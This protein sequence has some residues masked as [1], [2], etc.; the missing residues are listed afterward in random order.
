MNPRG[1]S[2]INQ[3]MKQLVIFLLLFPLWS[4]AQHSLSGSV[5]ETG[6]KAV[7]FADVA[8][9][10]AQD[11]T[12]YRAV[13]ADE[14]GFFTIGSVDNGQYIL[15]ASAIGM[16]TTNRTI[17]VTGDQ[18]LQPIVLSQTA[19]MLEGVEIV[20]KRPI[21]KRLVDR[22]EFNVE[23]SSL[24]SNNAWEI[25]SKTPGVTT[26]G[27]GSISIRGSQSILVT[28][29]DKKVY[30][31]GD[32]LKQYLESTSGE[33]V[34]SV[35]VIT[36]PPAKY[37]AQGAAVVNIK[38]KKVLSQ[39]YKGSVNTAYV[40]SIYPKAVTSTGHFYK[41][42]KLSLMGRYTFGMGEYVSE[43]E[44]VTRYYDENG[45]IASEWKSFL[46]RKSKSLEQHSYRLQATYELDSLNTF[47]IG[48][49]AFQAPQQF[50]KY[51][52]PTAIY[53]GDRLLDSLYVTTNNRKNPARNAAYN[54]LYERV[55]SEKAKLAINA[56]FTNYLSKDNQ[57][58]NT[59]F[60]LPDGTPYRDTRFVNNS[61]QAIKLF[62]AQ[63]DYSNERNGTFESGLKYSNVSADSNLD[64]RDDIGGVLV[65]NL[66]RTSKFL[67]D[68]SI[69]AGYVSYSKEFGK[70][71]F[72]AGLRGEYTSL[73]GNS[74]TSSEVNGQDYFKLF[75]T[76]YSM[77]KPNENH[78]IGFSYGKRIS[79]PRYSELNPFRT[80]NNNY[81][82]GMGDP[83]LLPTITHNLNFLYTLKSKYN[84]DLFYRL[85]KDPS[86]E[87]VYQDYEEN[88]V[89]YQFTNI[90]KNYA[91]GLEFNT[92]LTFFNWWDA[93]LQGAFSYVEDRFQGV[94]GKMYSNGRP[95]YSFS[96]NNRFALNKKKDF[97]GE[98]N[99]NYNSSSVQGTFVFNPT[100]NLTLAL[101]KKVLK[102]N[103]E[104][105]GIFSD[106]YRGERLKMSTDYGNQYN[107]SR[108]YSDTQN[109]RL[110]FRYNFGNQKLKEKTRE[111][112]EE[113]RRI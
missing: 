110:G 39:G 16:S 101:R 67:Y 13:L 1:S 75:P 47:T 32:E 103:G 48:S 29:N 97:N 45:G 102:G 19:E 30:M 36:N 21:V 24:A 76:F 53:G 106:V 105:Y 100:S 57:D 99:F 91:F 38:L 61:R 84:F 72:K 83:N 59:A 71:S 11:S 80:Y 15:K 88:T 44:D 46:R 49:T 74:V 20:A 51:S 56:D 35:E 90:D 28:I 18:Q 33:D 8:L 31:S 50:G 82:Y 94:D 2:I 60:S 65:P 43:S 25:L 108:Y 7:P 58:I 14:E 23:N 27:A 69:F 107:K 109:L 34:K 73:E 85:E 87:I 77:Y 68:E 89:V 64:F 63:A 10:K 52:S 86:M 62:S 4:S 104:V 6:G 3:I 113:Q 112:T 98:I 37:D 26:T 55:L 22:M 92:N 42:K 93:G 66:R 78:E 79:R 95:T 54:F 17:T 40:Q 9:L 12:A 81:S 41:G 96:V 70:W 111:Q 5:T